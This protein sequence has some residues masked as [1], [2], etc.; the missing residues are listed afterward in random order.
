MTTYTVDTTWVA[1]LQALAAQFG[2]IAP[3]PVITTNL[4]TNGSFEQPAL[5]PGTFQYQWQFTTPCPGWSMTGG[6]GLQTNNSAWG[7]SPDVDGN[8]SAMIQS[9]GSSISQVFTAA[10]DGNLTLQFYCARRNSQINPLKIT[11]DGVQLGNLITPASIAWQSIS[12]AL[13]NVTKGTHT[14]AFTGT[15]IG[16]VTTFVDAVAVG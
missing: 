10:V 13:P 14:I 11:L 2:G 9:A 16:D 7:A 1:Q 8:Q 3:P 6:S 4:L 15:G 5:A 12:V